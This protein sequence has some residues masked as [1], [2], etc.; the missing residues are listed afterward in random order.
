MLKLKQA[1]DGEVPAISV[2]C[3]SHKFFNGRV[4]NI[5]E[6]RSHGVVNA[7]FDEGNNIPSHKPVRFHAESMSKKFQP[8][9]SNGNYQVK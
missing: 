7:F 5:N 3:Q 6:Q 9:S 1:A 2:L 4:F 8:S